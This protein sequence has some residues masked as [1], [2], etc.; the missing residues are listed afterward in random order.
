MNPKMSRQSWVKTP[1]AKTEARNVDSAVVKLLEK[2]T[3]TE[4]QWTRGIGPNGQPA[5]LLRFNLRG[6]A[7]RIMVESLNA[8]ASKEELIRQAYRAIFH[9]LKSTLEMATVFFPLESLMFSFL[10]LPDQT[11]MYESASPHL[12]KLTAGNFSQ[13]MLPPAMR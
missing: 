1:Y 6:R 12:E 5:V 11:T 8:D 13:L 7:Y 4:Y 9:F 10:E 3:V 2:Y